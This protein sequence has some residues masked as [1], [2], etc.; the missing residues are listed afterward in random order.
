MTEYFSHLLQTPVSRLDSSFNGKSH[1]GYSETAPF[2]ECVHMLSDVLKTAVGFVPAKSNTTETKS[3]HF[4]AFV[5]VVEQRTWVIL[6][7]SKK[8]G[9]WYKPGQH[10]WR[11][12]PNKGTFSFKNQKNFNQKCN[13]NSAPPL[14]HR[15][16]ISYEFMEGMGE[17][18]GRLVPLALSMCCAL[19]RLC[20][21]AVPLRLRDQCHHSWDI[22]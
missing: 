19:C 15:I 14:L 8:C 22:Q 7:L 17:G 4:P 1:W 18:K 3:R 2:W 16:T 12:L 10:K 20:D 5:A 9:F 13:S 11:H 6:T 21:V